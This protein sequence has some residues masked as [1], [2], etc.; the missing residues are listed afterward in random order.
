MAIQIYNWDILRKYSPDISFTNSELVEVLQKHFSVYNISNVGIIFVEDEYIHTLNK[1]YRKKDYITDV[2]SFLL[3]TEPLVGEVYIAPC[4][5]S[6]N[7]S[8]DKFQEEILRNIV[9][10]ILHLMGYDHKEK[11]SERTINKE[12]MFVKQEEM[13]ENIKYEVN[14]RTGQSRYKIQKDKA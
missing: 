10:G 3:G 6:K 8:K 4:Y 13:L 11:F 14:N 5:V 2:L 12:K 7:T 1:Q 9:H